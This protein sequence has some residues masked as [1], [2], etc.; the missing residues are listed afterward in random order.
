MH[1]RHVTYNNCI[2]SDTRVYTRSENAHGSFYTFYPCV[3]D[4]RT[5]YTTEFNCR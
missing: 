4:Y 5:M 1:F 3:V 2:Q